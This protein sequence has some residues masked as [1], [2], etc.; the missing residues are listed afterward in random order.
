LFPVAIPVVATD[1]VKR[2]R[3][4]LR[5]PMYFSHAE[6]ATPL[7][8]QPGRQV[9]PAALRAAG[10]GYIVE[11]ARIPGIERATFAVAA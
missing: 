4:S 7:G 5:A 3:E 2:E 8:L 11:A 10:H 1:E 6:D 9:P